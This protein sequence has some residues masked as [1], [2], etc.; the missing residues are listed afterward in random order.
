M[1]ALA[2]LRHYH[3]GI[4]QHRWRQYT[5][6]SSGP[7]SCFATQ[8]TL[9]LPTQARMASLKAISLP[10]LPPLRGS[11]ILLRPRTCPLDLNSPSVHHLVPVHHYAR[12]GR[13]ISTLLLHLRF[14]QHP[15]LCT[16]INLSQTLPTWA[17]IAPCLT[18]NTCY[19]RPRVPWLGPTATAP[20]RM[21]KPSI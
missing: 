6:P 4:L 17:R 13:A 2:I 3:S 5:S 21:E 10:P 20:S 16:S 14:P 1:L 9:P 12:A 15:S 18:K 19:L 8:W 7:S 11:P